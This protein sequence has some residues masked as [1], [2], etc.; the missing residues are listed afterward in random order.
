MGSSRLTKRLPSIEV[1][2]RF[3]T[4]MVTSWQCPVD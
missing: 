2:S 1:S 4:G 3:L